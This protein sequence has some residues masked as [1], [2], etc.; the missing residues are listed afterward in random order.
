MRWSA[1]ALV[2][3]TVGWVATAGQTPPDQKLQSE[4]KQLFPTAGGFTAK[5]GDP[6]HITAFS[7]D[8]AG[9]RTP[10]G[11]AFWTTDLQPLERAYD[12]PIKMLVGM[13]IKG[14]L[15]GVIVVE[16]H[17]PFGNFSIE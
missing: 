17:E 13:D 14:V 12:G 16:H 5:E 2:L 8:R 6:P 4:L 10:L 3:L 1:T 11:F 15:T 9:S 7:L